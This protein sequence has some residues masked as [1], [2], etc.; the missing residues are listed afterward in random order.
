MWRTDRTYSQDM[1][2]RWLC[3]VCGKKNAPGTPEREG[4]KCRVCDSTWRVRATALAVAQNLTGRLQPLN[5]VMSNM[6][7]RGIGVSDHYVLAGFLSS[8]FDY[9]NTFLHRFPQVDICDPPQDLV[10]SLNFVICSDVLEHVPPPVDTALR[11]LRSMLMDAGGFAVITVPDKGR[12]ETDEYYPELTAWEELDNGT[13]KWVDKLGLERIDSNPEYHGGDGRTLAF[14]TWSETD[15][16]QR[17]KLAGFSNIVLP[18]WDEGLGV[19][20]I[21]PAGV[22]IAFT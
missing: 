10:G 17:L 14:R 15:L 1:K 9:T 12:E 7:F 4:M 2:K 18:P 3:A 13:V 16:I 22:V 20:E 19:P 5:S 11:G 21:S 8:K 6:A